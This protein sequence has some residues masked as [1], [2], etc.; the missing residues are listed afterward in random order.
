MMLKK[1]LFF[2]SAL[3]ACLSLLGCNRVE[4]KPE[5]VSFISIGETYAISG[6]IKLVDE[7]RFVLLENN[8]D[9]KTNQE[10]EDYQR[11]NYPLHLYPDIYFAEGTYVKVGEDYRLTTVRAVRVE[12]KNV[13][14]I[15]AKVISRIK[16]NENSNPNKD[17]FTLEKKSDYYMVNAKLPV[18]TTDQKIP[19]SIDEF[20][21]QYQYEPE[22]LE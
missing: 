4:R 2:V 7:K 14:N 15:Q 11:D 19:D 13:K 22:E 1:S 8:A 10:I 20:L 16:R 18:L 5:K 6:S 3:L 21:A 17:Y 12:F 9:F